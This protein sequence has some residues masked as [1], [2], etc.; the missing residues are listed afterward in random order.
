MSVCLDERLAYGQMSAMLKIV[1]RLGSLALTIK[2]YGARSAHA[3]PL[4]APLILVV[5][6][7]KKRI[8]S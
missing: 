3:M 4:L 7:V 6:M 1:Y 5:R 8:R 2:M